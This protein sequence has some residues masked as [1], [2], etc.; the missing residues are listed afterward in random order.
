MNLT[1]TFIEFKIMP[2]NANDSYYY[3]KINLNT[4][5]KRLFAFFDELKKS[6]EIYSKKIKEN[7]VILKKK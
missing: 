5:N 6:F 2:K 1:Q 7:K 3:K 4:F